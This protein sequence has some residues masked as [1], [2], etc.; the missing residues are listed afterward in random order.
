MK[1]VDCSPAAGTCATSLNAV[2][3]YSEMMMEEA[4]EQQRHTILKNSKI[5]WL[6]SGLAEPL[7]L[8]DGGARRPDPAGEQVDR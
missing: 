3:G 1:M 6:I 8:L 4:Q 2:I 7:G 5:W